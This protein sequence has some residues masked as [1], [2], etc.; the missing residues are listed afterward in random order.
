MN[1]PTVSTK[2][3]RILVACARPM[4]A[5]LLKLNVKLRTENGR[6][7][8]KALADL[9][10][11]VQDHMKLTP[12]AMGLNDAD[13]QIHLST[14]FP[15]LDY[16]HA[17]I[18]KLDDVTD[19]SHGTDGKPVDVHRPGEDLNAVLKGL[20]ALGKAVEVGVLHHAKPEDLYEHLDSGQEYDVLHLVCHGNSFGA[21]LLEDGQGW[22]RYVGSREL[23]D[24]VKNRVKI[25]VNGACHGERSIAALRE[26]QD[27]DRPTSM[28]YAKGEFP[29]QSRA[30]HLFTEAFYRNLAQGMPSTQAFGKG[31]DKVRRDDHVGEVACPDG[32]SKDGGPSPFKRID[33]DEI[34][35]VVFP[36]IGAGEVEVQD[37][38]PSRPP[39]RRIVPGR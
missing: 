25:I 14:P 10:S 26:S 29:I 30:V 4:A 13:V 34:Q 37:L 19:V 21:V 38:S 5:K 39:H 18:E 15:D 20:E 28:I 36:S 1:S 33:K 35:A 7:A 23:A 8:E 12:I 9:F 32:T 27:G 17:E 2:R 6:P 22:A 3:L 11:C 16:L 24:M 31:V